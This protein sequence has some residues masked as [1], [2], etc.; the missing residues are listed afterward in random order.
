[1]EV[2]DLMLTKKEFFLDESPS[3]IGYTNGE[4]WNGWECPLFSLETAKK[5]LELMIDDEDTSAYYDERLDKI[6]V[7]MNVSTTPEVEVYEP[8]TVDYNGET[9]KVY[10]VGSGSW[11]W[12]QQELIRR[13]K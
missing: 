2:L 6:M 1:M 7:V 8:S 13:V 10:N 11:C 3:F 9:I 12:M 5:V 4:T